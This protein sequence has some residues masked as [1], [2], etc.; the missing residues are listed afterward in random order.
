MGEFE[1]IQKCPR[2]GNPKAFYLG[3]TNSYEEVLNCHRCGLFKQYT[4]NDKYLGLNH[5]ELKNVDLNDDQWWNRVEEI[6]FIGYVTLTC[7][8]IKYPE[9]RL[10]YSQEDI[11]LFKMFFRKTIIKPGTNIKAGGNYLNQFI[12]DASIF[13]VTNLDSMTTKDYL[14]EDFF[15]KF[16]FDEYEG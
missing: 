12:E 6:Q 3:Y 9:I 4:Y 13:R 8:D 7:Q 2:C 16:P 11:D 14:P 1:S 15:E 10:M 5:E